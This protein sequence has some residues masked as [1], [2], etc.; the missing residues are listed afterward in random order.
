[1]R[2][3]TSALQQYGTQIADKHVSNVVAGVKRS[4]ATRPVPLGW[5]GKQ[6]RYQ[7]EAVYVSDVLV[8]VLGG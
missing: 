4:G 1:M 5:L 7:A 2:L 3:M 8:E 6:R